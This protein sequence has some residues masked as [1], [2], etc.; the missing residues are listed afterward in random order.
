MTTT[1]KDIMTFLD[2]QGISY[3]P[4]RMMI[5]LGKLD[6]EDLEDL[7][8]TLQDSYETGESSTR[9]YARSQ[10]DRGYDKGYTDGYSNGAEN[11]E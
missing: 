11:T 1:N 6:H 7:I 8:N 2:Y 9:K 3:N 4:I 5:L 10:Y